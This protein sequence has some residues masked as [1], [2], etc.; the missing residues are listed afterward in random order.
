M[1]EHHHDRADRAARIADQGAEAA[2]QH[3]TG[4]SG[5][6]AR[7]LYSR[8][9]IA[10]RGTKREHPSVLGC[11]FVLLGASRNPSKGRLLGVIEAQPDTAR[12]LTQRLQRRGRRFEPVTAHDAN[13]QVSVR[14]RLMVDTSA[15]TDRLHSSA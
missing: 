5:V 4:R 15:S 9:M 1:K 3:G 13:D 2:A 6:N 12:C 10:A 7:S 14:L 11:R 8:R